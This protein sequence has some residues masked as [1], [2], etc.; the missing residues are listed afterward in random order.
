VFS[1]YHLAACLG[2]PLGILIGYWGKV[3]NSMEFVIEFF[4]GFLRVWTG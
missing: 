3:Y 2:I 4:K 1:G